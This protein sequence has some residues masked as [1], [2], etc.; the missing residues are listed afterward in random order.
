MISGE[1]VKV[2]PLNRLEVFRARPVGS[3]S[4]FQVLDPFKHFVIVG[5]F[6]C[7]LLHLLIS[8]DFFK[9]QETQNWT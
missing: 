6:H 1:H 5:H 3:M 7:T 2:M 9:F 8:K 4:L